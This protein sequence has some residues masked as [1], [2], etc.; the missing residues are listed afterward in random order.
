M[1][2]ETM[3]QTLI[4]NEDLAIELEDG[5]IIGIFKPE[6]I[7]IEIAKKLVK[8]RIQATAGK[9]FPT[10]VN[11]KSV[12]SSTKEARDFFASEKGCEGI[13]ATALIIDSPL[14]SMIGNFYIN[15]SRPLRP[16]RLFTD[17]AKA[18]KWLNQ[19]IVH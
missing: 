12:K 18:K 15:I 5:I 7:D 14:G 19:F 10:I 9:H 2:I 8:Y 4:E 3:K 6:H 11:I 17:E 1:E 16:V 13:I